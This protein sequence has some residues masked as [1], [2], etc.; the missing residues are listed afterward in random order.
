MTNGRR[1]RVPAS[2]VLPLKALKRNQPL[3]STATIVHRDSVMSLMET[4]CQ[5]NIPNLN[6]CLAEQMQF[7]FRGF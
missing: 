2:S 1:G 5:R 7:G 6:L 4:I 3:P